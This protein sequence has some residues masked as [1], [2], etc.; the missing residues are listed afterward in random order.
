MSEKKITK[1]ET[2]V[3]DY[4]KSIN[5]EKIRK[6]AKLNIKP[7]LSFPN[8]NLGLE[9]SKSFIIDSLIYIATITKEK[10]I[11]SKVDLFAIDVLY[12]N[13]LHQLFIESESFK[14]QLLVIC[15]KLG[16]TIQ[17]IIG[18]ELLA[19]KTKTYINTP[20]FKGNAI[21][22]NLKLINYKPKL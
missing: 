9:H 6:S 15:E 19:W 22:Y 21:V 1:K 2:K 17:D 16:I 10:A 14:Y 3:I 5:M 13:T 4:T 18:L 20:N 12:L 11:T 7:K 8:E